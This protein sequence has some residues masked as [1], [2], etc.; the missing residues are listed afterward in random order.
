MPGLCPFRL[1]RH[2]EEVFDSEL[3]APVYKFIVHVNPDNDRCEKF[4]RQ[5]VEIKTYGASPDNIKAVLDETVRYKWKFKL[6]K[7]FKVSTSFTH[8]HQIKSVGGPYESIPMITLTARKATPD[9]LELR[10]T[11]TNNQ[12]T[13][14]SV[15]LDLLRGHWVEV[16]EQIMFGNNGSYAIEIN[17]VSNNKNL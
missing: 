11:P 2:I 16:T 14:A 9:R 15:D 10:Y 6:P 17:K 8:I 4:D 13:I 1:G 5:R 12:T 7:D 3:G